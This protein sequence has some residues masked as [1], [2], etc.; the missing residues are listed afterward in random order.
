M[1]GSIRTVLAISNELILNVHQMGVKT[2]F[3]NGH[4]E[5]DIYIYK[6]LTEH[7]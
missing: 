2:A 7:S 5:N 1:G 3:L 4:L 6:G